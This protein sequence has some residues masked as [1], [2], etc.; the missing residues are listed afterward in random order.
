MMN[1]VI[2]SDNETINAT[3]TLIKFILTAMHNKNKIILIVK[4]TNNVLRWEKPALIS[5]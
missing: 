1:A 4:P 2:W 3:M 5:L